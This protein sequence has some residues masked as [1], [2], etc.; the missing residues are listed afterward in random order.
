MSDVS[1]RRFETM[2]GALFVGAAV[3]VQFYFLGP[4]IAG[5]NAGLGISFLIWLLVDPRPKIGHQKFAFV[6]I[7]G[8]IVQ[9][10]HVLEEYLTGFYLEFPGLFGYQWTAGLFLAFNLIWLGLFSLAAVGIFFQSRLA[11][12]LVLF[13]ALVGGI[14]NGLFHPALSIWEGRYFP[15]L[16][17]SFFLFIIGNVIFRLLFQRQGTRA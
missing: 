13:F 9:G 17:T 1:V 10:A 8:L 7:I 4:A 16:V 5:L 12:L 3:I 6:Y 11:L 2:T 15:G 14:G